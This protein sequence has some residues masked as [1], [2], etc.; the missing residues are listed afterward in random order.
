MACR[1]PGTF[2]ASIRCLDDTLQLSIML[3][4]L[5]YEYEKENAICVQLIV[6]PF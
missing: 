1:D 3:D 2:D 6:L 4:L 5:I